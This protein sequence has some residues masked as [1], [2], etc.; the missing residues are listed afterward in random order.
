MHRQRNRMTVQRVNA[1]QVIGIVQGRAV[2]ELIAPG[3]GLHN[4]VM[5]GGNAGNFHL[6]AA[7]GEQ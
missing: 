5:L 4:Q 7:G 1:G 3:G 2:Q 6:D